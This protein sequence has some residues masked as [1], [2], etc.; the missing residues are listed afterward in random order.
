MRSKNH[1]IETDSVE[2]NAMFTPD[3]KLDFKSRVGMTRDNDPLNRV[4]YKADP[5]D[6]KVEFAEHREL[7]EVERSSFRAL[8]YG[9][10]EDSDD[11]YNERW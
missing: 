4:D 10:D 8:G 2:Y 9:N 3:G 7:R 5:R 11:N 1:A 6:G